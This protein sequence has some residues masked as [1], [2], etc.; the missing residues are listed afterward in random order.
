MPRI[1]NHNVLESFQERYLTLKHK[2]KL[3][4]K[5][6]TSY[7]RKTMSNEEAVRVY[8]DEITKKSDKVERSI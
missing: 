8:A 2:V 5:L 6:D 4:L 7:T 1:E 3:S